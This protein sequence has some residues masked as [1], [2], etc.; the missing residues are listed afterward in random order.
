LQ[1]NAREF[2]I[3]WSREI[4]MQTFIKKNASNFLA[5]GLAEFC[6]PLLERLENFENQLHLNQQ[7]LMT[8]MKKAQA[9]RAK[10]IASQSIDHGFVL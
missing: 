6:N 10:Y 9:A 7:K 5:E 4:P 1:D 8:S 2:W 3:V